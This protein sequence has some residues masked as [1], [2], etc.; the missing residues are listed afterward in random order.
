MLCYRHTPVRR[1]MLNGLLTWF[2]R[3]NELEN[4]PAPV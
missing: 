3:F 2:I 1:Y 4:R